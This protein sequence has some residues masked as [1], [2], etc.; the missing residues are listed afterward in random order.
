MYLL[1]Y[2]FLKSSKEWT[3]NRLAD[4]IS[5]TS[6]GGF[7]T[8]SIDVRKDQAEGRKKKK[9]ERRTSGWEK[10]MGVGLGGNVG[11]KEIASRRVRW[12]RHLPL[13][14]WHFSSGV[15]RLLFLSCAIYW[16]AGSLSVNWPYIHVREAQLIGKGGGHYEGVASK[17]PPKDNAPVWAVRPERRWYTTGRF[18]SAIC[19]CYDAFYHLITT[20]NSSQGY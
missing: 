12:P 13:S 17:P 18:Q 4:A 6:Y 3:A 5:T 8:I 19:L 2:N 10:E 9:I 11:S 20:P 7:S 14:E 1:H 16:L 15:A